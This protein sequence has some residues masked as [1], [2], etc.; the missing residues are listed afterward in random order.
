MIYECLTFIIK[1]ISR[2]VPEISFLIV[3]LRRKDLGWIVDDVT[4]WPDGSQVVRR[5]L[6]G[7]KLVQA[8]E[9]VVRIFSSVKPISGMP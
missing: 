9:P 6:I 3:C 4:L 2:S 1:R 8:I 7:V 5:N